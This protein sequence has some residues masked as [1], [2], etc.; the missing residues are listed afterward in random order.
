MQANSDPK[1]ER[2]SSSPRAR[3]YQWQFV[4]CLIHFLIMRL[5]TGYHLHQTSG[6]S[7]CT[8]PWWLPA[9]ALLSL[10]SLRATVFMS[11]PGVLGLAAVKSERFVV[12]MMAAV[13]TSVYHLLESSVTNRH[14]EYP[15]LYNTWAM[16]LPDAYAE[17]VSLGVAINFVLSTGIAK[18]QVGGRSWMQPHTMRTYLDIYRNSRSVPPLSKSFNRWLA[19]R[20]WATRSIG[21][22]TLALEC[23]VIPSTLLM[24]PTWRIVGS[25]CMI[26]MH[27]GIALA[28]SGMVGF[29]FMTALPSYLVGFGCRATLGT[30][31]WFLAA[32]TAFLPSVYTALKG[33]PL[34]ESWPLTPTA[35]FMWSG[36][37][38]DLLCRS[39]MNGETKVVMSTAA[40]PQDV[41]NLRNIPNGGVNLASLRG[42]VVHDALT[43]VIGFTL[44]HGDL[45]SAALTIRENVSS[46]TWDM[47][48]FLQRLQSW[49][50]SDRRLIEM[51]SG[52][53]LT[54]AFFVRISRGR[55]ADVLDSAS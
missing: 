6:G 22:G 2:L 28:M 7:V 30:K 11:L 21:I 25:A 51:H 39:L 13:V 23:I 49:L 52:R 18:L 44:A 9:R 48:V 27:L 3:F 41:T 31:P 33:R 43:R 24:P 38:A 4:C 40:V 1:E 20:A 5:K 42:Q 37:H 14:G 15:L 55:V 8:R 34:S 50:A 36:E 53:A 12:R 45:A 10:H 29:L 54:R 35:L 32:F 46:G 19:Q 17:A 26:S 47:R 16:L